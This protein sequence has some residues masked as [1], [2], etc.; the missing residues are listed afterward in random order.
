MGACSTDEFNQGDFCQTNPEYLN[1]YGIVSSDGVTA[2][3]GG[4]GGTD[5]DVTA[6]SD[7]DTFPDADHVDS[8][9]VDQE[10]AT[11]GDDIADGDTGDAP[12]I[13]DTEE[14]SDAQDIGDLPDDGTDV[15]DTT[16]TKDA[17]DSEDI[18]ET[19]DDG[20]D[21]DDGGTIDSVDVP[22]PLLCETDMDCLELDDGNLCNDHW[23]C[24]VGAC[25]LVDIPVDC[26]ATS[27]LPCFVA[28]CD[29]SDGSCKPE[30]AD[31]ATVCDDGDACTNNDA[32]ANG[33]CLGDP[34]SCPCLSNDDCDDLN[35]DNLCT[36]TFA[37]INGT[38]EL[39]ETT[40]VVCSQNPCMTSLCV[41]SSGLCESTPKV[42][43][44]GNECTDDSCADDSCVHTP[45]D[46]SCDDNNVCTDTDVCA[47][48][49]C[50]GQPTDCPCENDLDC[51][52]FD[53]DNLCNGS[54][55]CAAGDCVLDE[56]TVVACEETTCTTSTCTPE[57]G[58]CQETAVL[59]NDNV[60]CTD[61]T[62]TAESGCTY[63]LNHA[64]CDDD[65]DCTL[66]ACDLDLGCVA[67]PSLGSCDDNDGCTISD[68]CAADLSCE[69]TPKECE[70][71][72]VCTNDSC[73]GGLCTFIFNNAPCD[74]GNACTS[75][76]MCDD[77]SCGGEMEC[78]CESHADCADLNDLNACNG[79][80]GCDKSTDIWTCKIDPSTIVSCPDPAN[81]CATSSCIPATGA[82]VDS[83]KMT[84]TPCNDGDPCT[85]ADGCQSSGVCE[86]ST[87]SCNDD[88]QCTIDSCVDGVGCLNVNTGPIPC[89]DDNTDTVTDQCS[90]G[91]CLGVELFTENFDAGPPVGWIYDSNEDDTIVF[92]AS[93]VTWDGEP[94]NYYL[95]VTV[96][97]EV[98]LASELSLTVTL[99]TFGVPNSEAPVLT[100]IRWGSPSCDKA[101][102]MLY[103]DGAFPDGFCGS[104]S[105]TNSF[106]FMN[107]DVSETTV[108][109]VYTIQPGTY[110]PGLMAALDGFATKQNL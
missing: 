73:L 33:V 101:G 42:C 52:D 6:G 41:S 80:Y 50:S 68:T 55:K 20:T 102:M 4:F 86:G 47:L 10:E 11:T 79:V 5:I 66:N 110:A 62:C 19:S 51:V 97:E 43:D 37:C 16:E 109:F 17:P 60:E 45:N 65:D 39:D 81:Q 23:E 94:G 28:A 30:M 74:D 31:D 34:T 36:G 63:T 78:D 90:A 77:G 57:T 96:H 40:I 98:T 3:G 64:F 18:P 92:E 105:K 44:D 88:N 75:A 104:E 56:T 26:S 71:G 22:D 8:D 76:D 82:C 32:C 83:L 106:A 100:W 99:P 103:F 69:G 2:D 108:T 85:V 24:V 72:D 58:E 91:V 29:P 21:T 107:P 9:I 14:T 7:S 27:T 93:A 12:D 61:D 48:G 35:D 13:P 38:C 54:F 59:C 53:D 1:C 25:E 89:D 70:D 84:N 46:I 67:S 87:N 15:D 95:G 49:D